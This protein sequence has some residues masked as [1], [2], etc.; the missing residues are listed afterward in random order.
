MNTQNHLRLVDDPLAPEAPPPDPL[1]GRVLDG[2]YLIEKVLGEGGMGIVYRAKHTKRIASLTLSTAST[3]RI[4]PKI[5]S[6]ISLPSS[7][8]FVSTVG[9]R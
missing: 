3:G 8:T 7:F 9:A 4:G 1:I 5:S 2:R 6:P